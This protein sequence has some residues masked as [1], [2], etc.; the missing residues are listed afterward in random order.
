MSLNSQFILILF[1]I[2]NPNIII[3]Q[4]TE[5]IL[6]RSPQKWRVQAIQAHLTY[7]IELCP[8]CHLTKLVKNGF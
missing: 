8:H 6:Y 2:K 7:P 4:I 1:E 5:Q 3:D